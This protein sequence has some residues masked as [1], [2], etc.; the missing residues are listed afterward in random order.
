ME[1]LVRILNQSEPL[2]VTLEE[3]RSGSRQR[4]LVDARSLAAALLM[5]QPF[6]RQQD[7]AQLLEISQPAVSQLL[8]RH[9]GLLKGF[10]AYRRK[11]HEIIKNQNLKTQNNEK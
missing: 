4:R 6:T 2:G 3:L 8:A 5:R 10:P 7:V 11:W 9:E 1:S